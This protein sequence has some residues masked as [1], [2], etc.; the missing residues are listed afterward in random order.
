MQQ[1]HASVGAVWT[2]VYKS[3]QVASL[4]DVTEHKLKQ[5]ATNAVARMGIVGAQAAIGTILIDF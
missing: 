2:G 1:L 3:G 5:F 4:Q